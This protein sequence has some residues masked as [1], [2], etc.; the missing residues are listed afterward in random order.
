MEVHYYQER[1]K[2]GVKEAVGNSWKQTKKILNPW[3][4]INGM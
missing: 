1:W 3:S 2:Q 4:R